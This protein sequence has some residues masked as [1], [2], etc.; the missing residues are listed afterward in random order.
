MVVLAM[1]STSCEIWKDIPGYEG[2]YQASNLGRIRSLDRRVNIAH[3][4]TRLMRGRVLRPAGNKHDPHL[5]VVLGHKAHG[6]PVHQLVARTFLGPPK[7]GQEVRHLDGDP[8]NNRA[9]NLAYGT[10]TENILDV[11]R[12]GRAWRRLTVEDVQAIRARLAKGDKGVDLAKEY[13]VSISCISFIKTGRTY[14]WL[15]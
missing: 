13:G 5:F 8:L 1:T 14:A 12:I 9:D 10:R 15:K 7:K 2:K 4:A 6:S 3:G 11:Y